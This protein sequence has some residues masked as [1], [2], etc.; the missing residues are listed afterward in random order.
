M[1]KCAFDNDDKLFGTKK[2]NEAWVNQLNDSRNDLSILFQG[3]IYTNSSM[4][5]FFDQ[6]INWFEYD[7]FQG[8]PAI[9]NSSGLR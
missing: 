2:L 3:L 9:Y 8:L 5:I 4:K 6:S 7:E 1:K